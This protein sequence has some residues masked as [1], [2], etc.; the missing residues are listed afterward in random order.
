MDSLAQRTTAA[1]Q[2]VMDLKILNAKYWSANLYLSKMEYWDLVVGKHGTLTGQG[3]RQAHRNCPKLKPPEVL[4]RFWGK[5]QHYKHPCKNTFRE[6]A[7][8]HQSKTQTFS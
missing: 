1:E 3:Y 7:D 4:T 8:I 6:S 2:T 5:T